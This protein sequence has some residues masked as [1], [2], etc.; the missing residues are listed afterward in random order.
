[1]GERTSPHAAWLDGILMACNGNILADLG[2]WKTWSGVTACHLFNEIEHVHGR[3]WTSYTSRLELE[4][5]RELSMGQPNAQLWNTFFIREL[6]LSAMGLTD[7]PPPGQE[8]LDK[9]TQ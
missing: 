9:E 8:L 1:M 7:R 4:N 2:D 3:M 6:V 5:A